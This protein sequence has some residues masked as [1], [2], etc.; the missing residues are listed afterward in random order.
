MRYRVVAASAALLVPAVARQAPAVETRASA[1]FRS[2]VEADWLFQE[3]LRHSKPKRGAPITTV[4]SA[5]PA[6]TPRGRGRA[7]AAKACGARRGLGH[8]SALE[9]VLIME[10]RT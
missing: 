5:P 6:V 2:Q 9:D 3:E 8:M 4:M 7:V 10:R 1:D